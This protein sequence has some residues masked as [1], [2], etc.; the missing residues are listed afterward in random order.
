[1]YTLQS[2]IWW[3]ERLIKRLEKIKWLTSTRGVYEVWRTPD[4]FWLWFVCIELS[5][6][7]SSYRTE[8]ENPNKDGIYLL[9][10]IFDYLVAAQDSLPLK[11][12]IES[13]KSPKL[14]TPGRW[15]WCW[16]PEVGE[17]DTVTLIPEAS[18]K[19]TILF[20]WLEVPC[21]FYQSHFH[22]VRL[23]LLCKM[24]FR[25]FIA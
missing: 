11:W 10:H 2:I 3:I 13:W 24:Q 25:K 20:E 15:R 5:C 9:M 12:M 22:F 8:H 1:M 16:I 14:K 23:F 21:F 7:H 18:I 6:L 19:L 4:I 17:E